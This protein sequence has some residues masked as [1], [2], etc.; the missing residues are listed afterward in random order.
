MRHL[1]RLCILALYVIAPALAESQQPSPQLV[2]PAERI[3]DRAINADYATYEATQARIRA[4][5]ERGT[6]KGPKVSDYHLAKA[7]CWLDVSFHEYTRNDRSPFPQQ[8]LAQ[9]DRL[10]VLMES[11]A[12][13]LPNDTPLV[14]EAER[15]RPDLWE[16]TARMKGHAGYRCAAQ[17]IACAE[18][19]L[20]HAGNEMKQLG[21][22]HA[23]PYV[24][25]AEDL[26]SDGQIAS[27][28]CVPAKV[29]VTATPAAPP[30]APTSEPTSFS[31]AALFNFAQSDAS[32]IRPM[33][34]E[35]LD[36]LITRAKAAGITLE[37]IAVTGY[38]DRLNASGRTD[39]NQKLS[40]GRA[41]TVAE[42]L[43]AAGVDR[44]LI[45]VSG[46]G[47]DAPVVACAGK[48][49]STH[50]L[51]ECLAPNRRVEVEVSATR[52]RQ[53]SPSSI[54]SPSATA[55]R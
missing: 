25:M 40:L 28:Q 34:R 50:D 46:R 3:S 42:L 4:L 31:A 27:E 53:A 17:K 12:A 37:S 30:P 7:Q 32:Q 24:Q 6:G 38:T 41:Q 45:V 10:I 26:V 44:S 18:V 9:S 48:F 43:V 20:V 55:S 16:A 49:N 33:T 47:E 8:A 39:Y 23:K 1:F 2:P 5:N 36:Q 29:A 35:R 14:N 54:A 21:W 13:P 51:E 52:L 11:N 22:R 15:L 19:E